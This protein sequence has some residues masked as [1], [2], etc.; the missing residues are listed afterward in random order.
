MRVKRY[1]AESMQEAIMKVRAELGREAVILHSKKFRRGGAFGLFGR[2]MFEVIAAV[3]LPGESEAQRKPPEERVRLTAEAGVAVGQSLSVPAA[4][5]RPASPE[6]VRVNQNLVSGERRAV[7]AAPVARPEVQ[8]GSVTVP[9]SAVGGP[10]QVAPIPVR[11]VALGQD[12]ESGHRPALAEELAGL[13]RM[14]HELSSQLASKGA[15]VAVAPGWEAVRERL[16]REELLPEY[17]AEVEGEVFRSC[18]LEELADEDRVR[19]IVRRHF[20]ERFVVE[21]RRPERPA[22]RRVV[23][24]VGP[25]GV[26]KTTTVAKLAAQYSLFGNQSVGLLTVDTYRI[27]AVDQLKTYAEIINLP[28]EVAFSP[29]EVK[30][31]LE[32]LSDRDVVLM[33]TAG[34]SQKN[35]AQ[36]AELRAYLAAAQPD[37]IHLVLSTTTKQRDLD[38]CLAQFKG[39]GYRHLIFTKL[40]ET[41]AFGAIYNSSQKAK[42][43]ITYLTFGQNV[44]DDIEEASQERLADLLVGTGAWKQ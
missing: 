1:E 24:L 14:I 16:V 9:V 36:M 31:A 18:S 38:D 4:V 27:A 10:A 17:V 40:D 3:E 23:A 26:G 11:G 13:R 29:D 43:P 35:D 6:P 44:P 33:D 32:R 15:D 34:R 41:D 37:E 8:V 25:T 28:V 7:V 39:T 30:S 19:E 22:K 42:C 12:G 20:L 21:R 2:P 5:R